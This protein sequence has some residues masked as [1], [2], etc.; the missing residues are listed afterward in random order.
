MKSAA[1]FCELTLPLSINHPRKLHGGPLHK[2]ALLAAA[3]SRAMCFGTINKVLYLSLVT[4]VHVKYETENHRDDY[5]LIIL[6]V[7][8]IYHRLRRSTAL[9]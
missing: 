7:L 3:E 4:R 5:L 9:L 2:H 6:Y 8:P 1:S